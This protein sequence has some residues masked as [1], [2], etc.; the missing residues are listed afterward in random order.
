[1]TTLLQYSKTFHYTFGLVASI[2]IVGAT[3]SDKSTLAKLLLR[4]Y[5]VQQGSIQID[6]IDIRSLQLRDL[7]SCIGGVSHGIRSRSFFD[8]FFR[9]KR[10]YL[11]DGNS[12]SK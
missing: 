9:F 12:S 5:E 4:F 7:Q 8:R 10:N 3:G 1:M 6:G 11:R 2:G